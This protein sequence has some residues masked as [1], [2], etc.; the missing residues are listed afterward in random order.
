MSDLKL[1][2]RNEDGKELFVSFSRKKNNIHQRSQINSK[3]LQQLS[4][5]IHI[6][7]NLQETTISTRCKTKTA[8][9]KEFLKRNANI[10]LSEFPNCCILQLHLYNDIYSR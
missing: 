4:N 7:S 5:A 1:V 3:K 10:I 8:W 2:K 9:K 6:F